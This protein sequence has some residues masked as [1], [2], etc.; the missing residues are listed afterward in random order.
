M[1][2][3]GERR[4]QAGDPHRRLFE[5]D[6]LRLRRMRGVVGGHAVDRPR[7]QALDQRLAVVLAAQRRV[8][9]EA[10]VKGSDLLVG[11]RQ[12]MRGGL[13]ADRHP[14]LLGGGND[15]DRLPRREVLDVDAG[16]L[17]L[18]QRGVAG[19]HRRLRDGGDALQAEDRRN[20]ALVHDAAA[21]ELG[22]LL[23]QGELAAD[24]A[25]VLESAAQHP[26]AADRQAV[27]R[28]AGGPGLGQL[29]HLGQLLAHHPARDRGQEADGDRRLG[30]GALAQGADVGGGVHGG[31]GVGHRQDPAVAAGG[32]RA[33]PGLDVLR[34]L[35]ARVRRWTCGSKKAG[36][37]RIPS[38]STNSASP[39]PTL[40]GSAS[41]ATS[42]SRTTRSNTPSIPAR[43]SSTPARLNTRSGAR[44]PAARASRAAR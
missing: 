24:Q 35:L 7:P 23:V 44:L 5:R 32:G 29:R 1:C 43:G 37:T 13:A 41:S 33:R 34:I 11:E 16:V 26:G 27:V 19:D 9:L 30:R 15:L 28:E 39:S 2:S 4:L 25:L 42:P 17:E 6:L 31:P 38:A 3:D 22:V 8:H 20:R 14:P 21:G 18:G 12:V 40:P 36:K 10:G